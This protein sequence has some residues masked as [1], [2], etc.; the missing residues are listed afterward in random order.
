MSLFKNVLIF[1]SSFFSRHQKEIEKMM[2]YI[3]NS[4]VDDAIKKGKEKSAKTA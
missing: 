1:M 2:I 3:V 4:I